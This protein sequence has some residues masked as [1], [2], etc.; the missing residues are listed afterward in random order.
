[1]KA[2]RF[3]RFVGPVLFAGLLALPVLVMRSGEAEAAPRCDLKPA[4]CSLM[5]AAEKKAGEERLAE[6]RREAQE[7]R[8]APSCDL[9]PA[10]CGLVAKKPKPEPTPARAKS[11]DLKPAACHLLEQRA[12]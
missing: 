12:E 10:A 11:C 5:K 7:T 4:A 9:K 6:R 1:M 3:A 8:R 2:H